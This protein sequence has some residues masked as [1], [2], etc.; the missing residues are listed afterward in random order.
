M[1]TTPEPAIEFASPSLLRIFAS[2]VYDSLLLAAI[3]IAYGALVVGIRVAVVGQP[4][5]GQ[6]I[7]WGIPAGILVTLGWL[8]SLMFFY[9]YFWQKF[10]QTLG[11]KTWRIQLVDAQTNQ[12]ISR[13]QGITRSLAAMLSLACLGIGYWLSLIHPQARLFHDVISGT[14]LILL[15]KSK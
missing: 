15:K 10:G 14:R 8:I 7:Q 2:M 6:R 12:L 5:A 11:M 4:E 9:V 3:S 1:K 13:S